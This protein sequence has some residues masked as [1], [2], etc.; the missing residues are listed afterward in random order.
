MVVKFIEHA[1]VDP[2][3]IA[4]KQT[5]YRVS[6]EDSPIIDALCIAARKGK[7][8]CLLIELKAR[9]D[10]AQNIEILDKLKRAGV[11]FVFGKEWLKTHCKLCLV[12]RAEKKGSIVY[13][14]VGTG[15][16]NEKTSKIYTDISYF[17][18]R[19]KVGGDLINIFNILSGVSSPDEKLQKVFYAPTNLR[20]KIIKNIDREIGYA[21]KGKKAEVFLKLNSINDP[22]IINKLYE[23]AD[24]G[25]EVYI[26]CRGI[27]SLVAKKNLYVK[28]IVGRF[29]EHSRIYYFR[30]D[31][32]PEYYIASADLLTRNLDRR[33]EILLNI[34]T[35]ECTRKLANIIKVFKEDRA[36]S[37][38]MDDDGSYKKLKGEFDCHQWFVD[39]ADMTEKKVKFAKR[40]KK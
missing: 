33:I 16:Y 1:A 39:N 22:E 40:D 12:V 27:C 20:K 13:S 29:L 24:K 21:K 25:V 15:N 18:S 36:N 8:V 31:D 9:N 11:N 17:T 4:I 38:R 6:S 30:N 34:N 14:H 32:K 5:L 26:I 10:E 37:F 7:N 28:S 23:A 35:Q 3:V 19:Q 2:K